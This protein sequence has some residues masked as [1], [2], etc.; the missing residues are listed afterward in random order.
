MNLQTLTCKSHIPIKIPK[1]NPNFH[2][3]FSSTRLR[4]CRVAPL[5]RMSNHRKRIITACVNHS[6]EITVNLENLNSNSCIGDEAYEEKVGEVTVREEISVV[7]SNGKGNFSGNESIW[8]QVVEIVK[9]SGPAVGLWLCG[10]LMSLIDT[11]VIGQGSSIELAALGPGTVFC[12]NTSYLFMFLSIAT[13]NLVATALAKGDKDDVQH[14]ISILLFIGL[15]CG[16]VMFIFTRLFGTWGITAFTGANNM[17][18]INAANTYVQIR[19]LA[20][21]AMLVGWVAQSASLGMKDS[22]GPLKAL[23][24]ATAINGVGDIVLCRFFGYGI[25]GAAWA[26]MVSQVVAA[27]MMIAALSGKGYTGFAL[28]VPSLDELLQ[29]FMLAAPVFLTMMSKVLFYSLLVYYAT[30]MGTHIAAAHQVLLQLFCIFAIWGEPLS[31]TAQSFMPE[32]LYGV[33]RNL[34]K[35]RMLLKSLLIIAVSNGLLLGFGGVSISWF[36]PKIFSP[37]PLVIHEMHKVLLP[38]FLTLWVSPCVHSLEGTLLAGRDLKFISISMASIF[39]LASLLVM[40]FS[41]R[42][43]GLSG[44]WFALVAFQWMRFLVA[45]RRLTLADGILYLE[46]PVHDELQKL[47]AA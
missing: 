12:D 43:F 35:A 7:D 11:A 31:Q 23:A 32:L 28:S 37:D 19:G 27:Y 39:G 17:E 46:N 21:P 20:W 29:I 13:S 30:S 4:T 2:V 10:P 6:Q 44:C 26:T 38:L 18:I 24:V 14:Q 40:L 41:S 42:G 15:A 33:N 22:W 45:L 3:D 34:S 5:T 16:I 47:K 25:A 8:A 36:F 9:F 1:F